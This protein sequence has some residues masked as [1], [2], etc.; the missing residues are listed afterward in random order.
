[1]P[2]LCQQTIWKACQK[3]AFSFISLQTWRLLDATRF[4]LTGTSFYGHLRHKQ[5]L[6]SWALGIKYDDYTGKIMW[7]LEF[8][9]RKHGFHKENLSSSVKKLK[10]DCGWIFKQ[11]RVPNICPR[12]CKNDRI[13]WILTSWITKCL[14]AVVLCILHCLESTLKSAMWWHA[15]SWNIWG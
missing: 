15:E 9:S 8:F 12:S 2:S 6:R 1:M 7:C 10:L 11:D 13:L 14:C 4:S 3:E 5:T